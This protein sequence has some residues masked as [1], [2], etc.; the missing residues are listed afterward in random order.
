[1]PIY[2]E[3]GQVVN[4]GRVIRWDENNGFIIKNP[5]NMDLHSALP[6]PISLVD[7]YVSFELTIPSYQ[8][9]LDE[10]RNYRDTIYASKTLVSLN[11]F[12]HP[13]IEFYFYHVNENETLM[14]ILVTGNDGGSHTDLNVGYGETYHFEIILKDY[15]AEIIMDDE[16][17]EFSNDSDEPTSIVPVSNEQPYLFISTWY[18]RYFMYTL[19]SIHIETTTVLAN[20]ELYDI[21]YW[22]GEFE[23]ACSEE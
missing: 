4:N 3:N 1:M 18:F 9:L 19:S 7:S 13:S 10:V 5:S 12:K 8:E 14:R 23:T 2:D 16:T 21:D 17:L 6:H 15:T 11:G 20:S 22:L